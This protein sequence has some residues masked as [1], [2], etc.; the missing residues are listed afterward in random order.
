MGGGKQIGVLPFSTVRTT[1]IL[2]VQT[3]AIKTFKKGAYKVMD[4]P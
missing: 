2:E 3:E 1:N 4:K